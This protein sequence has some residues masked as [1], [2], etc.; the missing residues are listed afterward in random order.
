[1]AFIYGFLLVFDFMWYLSD[2]HISFPFN[3]PNEKVT[4]SLFIA[5]IGYAVFLIL[6][7][8]VKSFVFGETFSVFSGINTMSQLPLLA[9]SIAMTWIGWTVV[10]PYI[11]TS[12]IFGR[13]FEGIA[14]LSY[15]MFGK[16]TTLKKITTA[17]FMV[18]AVISLAFAI[19][20]NK[21]TG[22]EITTIF[23]FG[24]VSCY[25]I[26]KEQKL[27][28]AILLHVIANTLALAVK[29]GLLSLA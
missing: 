23:I 4:D 24:M 3:R 6:N 18:A 13:L 7:A 5:I 29:Y 8:L 21:I 9:G 2:K 15:R 11:E 20:H 17:L 26:V 16:P 22:A 27:L 28:G 25:I 19:F 10:I 14:Q 1:M 12:F